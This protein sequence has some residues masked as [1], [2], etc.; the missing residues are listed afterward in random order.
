[1]RNKSSS[2]GGVTS[3]RQDDR[4]VVVRF[5]AGALDYYLRLWCPPSLQVSGCVLS[6]LYKDCYKLLTLD[7]YWQ[8]SEI[9]LFQCYF[10]HHKS[11][12][13]WPGIESRPSR[14]EIGIKPPEPWHGPGS[15]WPWR[16]A[17]PLTYTQVKNAWGFNPVRR[18]PTW[19]Q[20]CRIMKQFAL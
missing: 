12:M 3:C 8:V 17:K 14:W 5:P 15:K 1:M 13:V 4:R 7:R 2:V 11:H 6:L 10:I 18:M 19:R 20:A 9:N 16:E